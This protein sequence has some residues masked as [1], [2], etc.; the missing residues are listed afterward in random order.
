VTINGH[1]YPTGVG[2]DK[3]SAEQLAAKNALD[4]L[5]V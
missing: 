3:K 4:G 1:G 5:M 2:T